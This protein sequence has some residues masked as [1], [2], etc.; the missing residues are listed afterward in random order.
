MSQAGGGAPAAELAA[1]IAAAAAIALRRGMRRAMVT[2][3]VPL[4][5]APPGPWALAG[6][7]EQMAA[8]QFRQRRPRGG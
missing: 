7:L 4:P 6:R 8:R 2:A 3:V 5:A 1:V